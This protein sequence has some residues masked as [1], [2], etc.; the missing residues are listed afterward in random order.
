M[1]FNSDM[2]LSLRPAFY[3]PKSGLAEIQNVSIFHFQFFFL[4][5]IIFFR[6]TH[7]P[8]HMLGLFSLRIESWTS[9]FRIKMF[10][11]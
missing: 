8:I 6:G 9:S 4:R 7:L 11:G 5:K 3:S 1:F 2:H 10:D